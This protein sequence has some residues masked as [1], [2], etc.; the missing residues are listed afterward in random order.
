MPVTSAEQE[1]GELPAFSIQVTDFLSSWYY[2]GG[3]N[4]WCKTGMMFALD[5]TVPTF[6]YSK[7]IGAG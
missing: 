7:V 6:L 3:Q 1:R 2:C 5:P 4:N